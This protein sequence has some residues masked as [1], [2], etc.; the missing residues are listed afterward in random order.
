MENTLEA[1]DHFKKKLKNFGKEP[2]NKVTFFMKTFQEGGFPSIDNVTIQGYK[3]RN[4]SSE[5]VPTND[6]LWLQKVKYSQDNN[7]YHYHLGFYGIDCDIEGYRISSEGDLTSQW[8]IHYQLISHSH[9]HIADMTPHPI[10]EL[11]S[12]DKLRSSDPV[13]EET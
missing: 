4:K 9:I 1:S 6:P 7:L 3:V 2:K 8:V 13:E 11:P 12:E 10:S 5:D